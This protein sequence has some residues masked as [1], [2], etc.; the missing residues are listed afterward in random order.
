[1]IALNPTMQHTSQAPTLLQM[2]YPLPDVALPH[3]LPHE[4][5]HH[6][7]DPLFSKYRILRGL[8]LVGVVIVDS[9]ER[10]RNFGFA[11][12]EESRFGGRHRRIGG[13]LREVEWEEW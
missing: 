9:V 1:M 11:R 6:A 13:K 3:L 4:P 5:R 8:E 10:W 7:L 2:I 12:E